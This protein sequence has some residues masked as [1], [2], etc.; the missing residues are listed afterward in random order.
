VLGEDTRSRLH[1]FSPLPEQRPITLQSRDGLPLHGYLTLPYGME[2][3]KL[4][5]VLYVHGGP[6]ARDTWLNGDPM[7][8]FLANRGYA[9]LQVNYRGSS[10]YGRVFQEAAQGE[11]AGKMHTDLLDGVDYLVQQGITDPGKVA[12]MGASYGGYASLVGMTFTPERFACGISFV[13]MSDLASLVE[14]APPYWEL[15]KPL[16]TKYVGDPSKPEARAVMNSKSPLY[17]ADKVQA[18]LLILHGAN[19]A[20]VKLDQSTRMVDALT[21]AGKKVDF[22][23]FKNAGHGDY[24]W[25]NRLTYY[26]KT[27]DFLA[28]C[29]GGRSNGFDYYQLASWAL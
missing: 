20:R 13:G 27:E 12:I 8:P 2:A 28:Q 18:P 17:F 4:P 19:D 15:S 23:V 11:F 9:V 29:L 3:K 22:H 10:G 5:T 24:S 26:R 1:A 14:N 7:V 21:L 25:S 16:W 6:W